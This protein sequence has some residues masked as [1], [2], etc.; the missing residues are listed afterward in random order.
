[1]KVYFNG[2][3]SKGK[4]FER[5]CKG[6]KIGQ[7]F[8]WAGEQWY[9]PAV[10]TC[11]QGLVVDLC[12]EVPVEKIYAFQKKWNLKDW[13]ITEVPKEQ[14]EVMESENPLNDECDIHVW[15]NEKQLKTSHTYYKVWFSG[16]PEDM[17]QD[18]ELEMLM[19]EYHLNKNNGWVI[20]RH[21]CKWE[22]KRKPQTAEIKLQFRDE[23]RA[24]V[25]DVFSVRNVGEQ[26]I[27][28]HPIAKTE[29]VLTVI[30]ISKETLE[31]DKLLKEDMIW[32][33]H[34]QQMNYVL[35]PGIPNGKLR[36]VDCE[37][38]D[39]PIRKS[40]YKGNGAASVAIIGGADGPTSVFIVGKKAISSLRFEPAETVKWKAVFYEKM[41]E[42][43]EIDLGK[44]L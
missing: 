2:H 32:P 29:H 24:F 36:I 17:A 10:Y 39:R 43:M 34:F 40:D 26:V 33:T 5:C 16:M 20:S 23:P 19:E 35:E 42:D 15:V 28:R 4:K 18:K 14:W 31:T 21:I 1:M 38:G 3:F 30:E 22:T 12:K 37:E 25:G 7:K 8:T 13:D 27:L 6:I 9:I 11:A 44:V 41:R